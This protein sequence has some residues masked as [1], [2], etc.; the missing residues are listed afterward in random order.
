MV[1]WASGISTGDF[2]GTLTLIMAQSPFLR[3]PR[4]SAIGF[5]GSPSP[6]PLSPGLSGYLGQIKASGLLG[7]FIGTVAETQICL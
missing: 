5:C 1:Y 4:G 6:T 2:S 7:L 3:F